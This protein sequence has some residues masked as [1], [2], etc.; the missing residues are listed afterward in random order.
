MELITNLPDDVLAILT[1]LGSILLFGL[2]NTVFG[3]LDAGFTNFS[4]RKLLT[5]L[6][7]M[8]G[9]TLAIAFIVGAIELGTYGATKA[10]YNLKILLPLSK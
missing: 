2:A 1:G 4:W 5:G 10:M 8:V 6:L 7:K 9:I 3:V